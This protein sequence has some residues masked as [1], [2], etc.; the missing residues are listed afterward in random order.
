MAQ[1][2]IN[3]GEIGENIADATALVDEGREHLDGAKDKVELVITETG[4]LEDS[5]D[6]AMHET[7]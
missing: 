7:A 3:I 4:A 1:Q 2:E 6:Q 5:Y